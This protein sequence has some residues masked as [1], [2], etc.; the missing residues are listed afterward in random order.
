MIRQI[1]WLL[2]SCISSSSLKG[3][4]TTPII[5]FSLKAVETQARLHCSTCI[6]RCTMKIPFTCTFRLLRDHS[7]S[8]SWLRVFKDM[9]MMYLGPG[10][11]I[12][13]LLLWLK[14][15]IWLIKN[16]LNLYN[17]CSFTRNAT[18]MPR[19][20][21]WGTW[22]LCYQRKRIQN[23]WRRNAWN[24]TWTSI[25]NNSNQ[26]LETT[27]KRILKNNGTFHSYLSKK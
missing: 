8:R 22:N 12:S 11:T 2:L 14:T 9:E 4:M 26:F 25:N 17:W 1:S 5:L 3:F 21:G 7:G 24:C 20:L 6:A 19:T 27:S 18:S 16:H 10:S 13:N 15:C 23:A